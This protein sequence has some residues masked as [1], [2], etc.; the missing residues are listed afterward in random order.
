MGPAA[1]RC[2]CRVR[3][4]SPRGG[5]GGRGRLLPGRD[6]EGPTGVRRG[7]T[8]VRLLGMRR[9]WLRG[10]A[11]ALLVRNTGGGVLWLSGK[12]SAPAAVSRRLRRL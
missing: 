4:P 9:G 1:P 5:V 12:R 3:G 6:V 2:L 8:G 11:A 10:L 7:P